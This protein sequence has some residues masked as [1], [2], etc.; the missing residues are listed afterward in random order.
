MVLSGGV[1]SQLLFFFCY[2]GVLS[3]KVFSGVPIIGEMEA[4][5]IFLEMNFCS[6]E[7]I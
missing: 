7:M 2:F 6:L 1:V 4:Q 3:W 5:L